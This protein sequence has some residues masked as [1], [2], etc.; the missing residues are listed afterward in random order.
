MGVRNRP[1]GRS[2]SNPP[3]C[4]SLVISN[5]SALHPDADAPASCLRPRLGRHGLP[6]SPCPPLPCGRSAPGMLS[7]PHPP[8]PGTA[9]G[10]QTP[11]PCR[12]PPSS[13]EAAGPRAPLPRGCYPAG[14]PASPPPAALPPRG[15]TPGARGRPCP[16]V[17]LPLRCPALRRAATRCA[18]FGAGG[19]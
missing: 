2:V 18:G 1:W 6:L 12:P 7:A 10:V 4:P 5:R 8:G 14:L 11:A 13:W 9:P 16:D 15:Q 17:P 3:C 19:P